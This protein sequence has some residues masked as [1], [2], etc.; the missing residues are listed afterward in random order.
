MS[1]KLQLLKAPIEADRLEWRVQSC[2]KKEDGTIWARVLAYVD[3]RTIMERLDSV[4][5]EGWD[6]QEAYQQIG[7]KAVC[8][9]QLRVWEGERDRKVTGSCEVPLDKESDIDPFKTA[10]SGAMKRAAVLLGIGRYLYDMPETWAVVTDRGANFGKTKDGSRFRW[11]PPR[12]DDATPAEPMVDYSQPAAPSPKPAY[13]ATQSAQPV[14]TGTMSL[15]DA[16]NMTYP[17]GKHKGKTMG[18]VLQVDKRAIEWVANTY[19]VKEGKFADKDR[20]LKLAAK[21]LLNN[22]KEET[23]D[24]VPF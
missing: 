18:E 4:F 19:E 10:A 24:D 1:S 14:T 9:V 20:A 5:P 2:G 8:V 12:L 16:T 11:D 17:F 22:N 21:T 15:D 7:N 6:Q 23:S 3:N 13:K